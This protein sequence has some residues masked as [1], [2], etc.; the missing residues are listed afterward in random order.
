MGD[1]NYT[2]LSKIHSILDGDKCQE[3][4]KGK[5]RMKQEMEQNTEAL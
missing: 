3:R 4:K 1:S 5:Q 2:K